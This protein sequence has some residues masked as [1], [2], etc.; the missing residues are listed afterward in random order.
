VSIYVAAS[1]CRTTLAGH[2][3]GPR[4]A[5]PG[6]TIQGHCDVQYPPICRAHCMGSTPP[7]RRTRL[8]ALIGV[9]SGLIFR[10][11]PKHCTRFECLLFPIPDTQKCEFRDF[12]V[13]AFGQKRPLIKQPCLFGVSANPFNVSPP[14]RI[15]LRHI[16]IADATQAITQRAQLRW[17][18]T[19]GRSRALAGNT[20]AGSR[21]SSYPG[22]SQPSC[23]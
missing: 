15:R 7:A 20:C 8:V 18:A 13:A 9:A 22:L 23:F 19:S 4:R 10:G 2:I 17:G 21:T 1:P 3:W 11:Q 5:A 12:W 14:H 6:H 16:P